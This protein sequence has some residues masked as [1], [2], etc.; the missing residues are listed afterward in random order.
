[1]WPIVEEKLNTLETMPLMWPLMWLVK[2]TKN[3]MLTIK[4]KKCYF[5]GVSERDFYSGG[6]IL[7][8][9][10]FGPPN[11]GKGIFYIYQ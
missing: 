2:W 9:N 1:M 7:E 6:K 8:K 3:E 4:V 11:F 5:S 10:F